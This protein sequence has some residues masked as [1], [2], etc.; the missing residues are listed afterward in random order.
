MSGT[1]GVGFR[2]L[3]A[4]A[5]LKPCRLNAPCRG[6]ARAIPRLDCLGLIEAVES[7][8]RAADTIGRFRGLIAS[9]SLKHGQA[10]PITRRERRIPRLDCLGLIEAM[11]TRQ[12]SPRIKRDSEA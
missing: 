9:A 11:R 12:P 8:R 3:I 5:S 7:R 6:P 10:A 4:S 2:G 1:S